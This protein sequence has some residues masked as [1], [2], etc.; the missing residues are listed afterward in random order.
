MTPEH[1]NRL[2]DETSPYLLQH[3]HNPV[4]WY[5]W[6]PDALDKAKTENKPIL[7]SIGYSACHWCHVMEHESFE[8]PQIA[9]M[10]NEHF[11]NIKVDREERPDLDHIYQSVVQMF[12]GQGGWPLTAF[13]TPDQEAFYGGTYYPP[14]DRHGRPGF[15]RILQSIADAY[16]NRSQDID[17]S[18]EQIRDGLKRLSTFDNETRELTP[19]L[20]ENGVHG[21]ANAIDRTHGGFGTQPKFPNPSNLEFILRFWQGSGNNNFLNM[22]RLSLDKM[23][24]GG[25]Y[26]QLGGGFHR[27]STDAHWLV[28]HFEKM[29]YDNA[30]L[31]PLYL[32]MYQITQAPLYSRI[33]RETLSYLK[34][35]M[36]HSEGGF[37]STQDADSEGVEGKFFVWT[38]DEVNEQLGDAARLFCRYYDITE[39]G[40]WEDGNN[41]PH[42]T[43]SLNQLSTL[44]N[45]EL[46][47]V[48]A[49]IDASKHTL[50][51]VRNQRIK[52]FRDEKI[53][54]AWNGLML[55]GLM[56][57]Y[58]VLGDT[59]ALDA[60]RTSIDFLYHHMWRDGRLLRTYKDGHARLNG[61][62]DDY[63]FLAAALLDGFEATF[64]PNYFDFAQTLAETMI[65]EFW[66]TDQGGFFFTG[67]S[68]E[69]LVNRTKS[70][71][72]EAIPSGNA[73]ATKTLLRLYHYTGKADYLRR[74]EQVLQLLATSMNSH[75]L[76]FGAMFNTLDFYLRKPQE[77]VLVGEPDAADTQALLK[78]IH[79]HYLPNKTLVRLDPQRFAANL[80]TLPLLQDILVGKTQVNG[81]ATVYVCHNFTCS[82]PITETQA[83]SAHL[84]NISRAN[85]SGTA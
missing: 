48:T 1:T 35:E 36:L 47:S 63:A 55:S 72:D 81:Q 19:S 78:V 23:A 76:G 14:E 40:N 51:H 45:Q 64:E 83:L 70:A 11:V 3:A 66:D 10:M 73:I 68:H 2:I 18:L 32:T 46:E 53:L 44:F 56:Q 5:P 21:L 26:D 29:L 59:K 67:N 16:H 7:L 30:Q 38:K 77:I 9:T 31:L 27:Y 69:T 28:P 60:A 34:R 17:K 15:V 61:Y 43:I 12:T 79:R 52:P 8:N 24:H 54:T 75:P 84:T 58:A 85:S 80:D 13:L 49:S 71:F 82:L 22:A 42:L 39:T 37:Y 33:A 50:F 6:G 57:A 62:L 65:D 4:D 41:I 74:A 20:L 25:I